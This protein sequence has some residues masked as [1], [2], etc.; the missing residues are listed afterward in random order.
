M[1]MA[2]S[3]FHPRLWYESS[4]GPNLFLPRRERDIAH[5]RPVA[6]VAVAKEKSRNVLQNSEEGCNH[7]GISN[8]QY[9]S[10]RENDLSGRSFVSVG[11]RMGSVLKRRRRRRGGRGA[12]DRVIKDLKRQSLV[13][14]RPP[15]GLKVCLYF[16]RREEEEERSLIVNLKRHT[17]L[18]DGP[19]DVNLQ[20]DLQT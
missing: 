1:V 4:C 20:T 8:E 10:W 14:T 17:Q 15:A 12:D 6:P 5:P 11:C 3:S 2:S 18:A 7:G 9:I 19:T 13:A 16:Y